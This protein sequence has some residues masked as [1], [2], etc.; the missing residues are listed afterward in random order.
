MDNILKNP[1]FTTD[2]TFEV[3]KKLESDQEEYNIG[4]YNDFRNSID[5]RNINQE[6]KQRVK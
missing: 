3:K 4:K 2:E 6:K 5:K 1:L